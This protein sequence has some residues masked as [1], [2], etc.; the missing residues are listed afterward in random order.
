MN[1]SL[2]TN[3]IC[4][5]SSGEQ[6]LKVSVEKEHQ[7]TMGSP[8]QRRKSVEEDS[9]K[10]INKQNI[11][12]KLLRRRSD[13]H[14]LEKKGIFKNEDIFGNEL[15]VLYENSNSK[16]PEFVK[17]AVEL[18]ETDRNIKS[19]HI[20]RLSG[21]MATI[22]KIRLKIDG[23]NYKVLDE[24][25]ND[26]DVLTGCLKLFYRELVEPLIPYKT[27]EELNKLTSKYFSHI[28]TYSK[29][30]LMIAAKSPS[31]DRDK[32]VKNAVKK[33]ETPNRENLL[34]LIQH[35]LT[36]ESYKQHNKMTIQ[37]LSIVWGPS[38][39]WYPGGE[40]CISYTPYEF[41][42]L[43]NAVLELILTT[44][45]TDPETVQQIQNKYVSW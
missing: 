18:I 45:Q 23:K 26:V 9:P 27:F 39:L 38:M 41:S 42:M 8:R 10:N 22:Q 40:K 36:V 7:I 3:K 16:V 25:K 1:S 33:M 20:Y 35:L 11:L 31:V 17:R 6:L 5:F 30:I 12:M 4:E 43:V 13:K 28:E 34:F 21:N 24:Y 32:L 19:E 14:L 44:Y 15:K 37:S 2:K 29:F